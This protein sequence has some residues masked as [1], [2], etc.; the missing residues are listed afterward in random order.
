MTWQPPQGQNLPGTHFS[1]LLG[2]RDGILW[3]DGGLDM[4]RDTALISFTTRQGVS[5]HGFHSGYGVTQVDAT[6]PGDWPH[7]SLRER[8]RRGYSCVRTEATSETKSYLSRP[9][10]YE[11][12][13]N[14]PFP[15]LRLSQRPR[16][17]IRNPG[18]PAAFV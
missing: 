3:I 6:R 12:V 9:T 2:S 10:D 13:C 16:H 4:F 15:R 5:E 1:A 8:F 11:T 14:I 17:A 18:Q 7:F